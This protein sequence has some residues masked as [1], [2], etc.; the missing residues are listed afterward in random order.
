MLEAEA[1]GNGTVDARVEVRAP[2]ATA[3]YTQRAPRPAWER[4]GQ[5][6]RRNTG[7]GGGGRR[8]R[9]R[10]SAPVPL[11]SDLLKE[12]QE[13]LVQIAKEPIGKKGARITSHIALPGRFLTVKEVGYRLNLSRH[14]IYRL[15]E[16]GE[17]PAHR[18]GRAVRLDP[19]DVEAFVRRSR[20]GD[21][22]GAVFETSQG[23]CPRSLAQRPHRGAAGDDI[24]PEFLSR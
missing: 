4:R 2:A 8:F 18:F 23:G 1:R 7:G 6:G 21:R 15:I 10:E 24:Q 5:R 11:I 12:G 17:L 14:A 20:Q 19:A 13:I 22:A 16:S 9:R 3:G